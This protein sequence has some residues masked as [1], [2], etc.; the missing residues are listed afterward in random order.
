MI[1]ASCKNEIPDGSK[2]CPECGEI[3]IS[4]RGS[5]P[6]K[7]EFKTLKKMAWLMAGFIAVIVIFAITR[8][9]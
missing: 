6:E 3:F 2:F 1:C 7:D 5:K 4:H 9:C 8:S